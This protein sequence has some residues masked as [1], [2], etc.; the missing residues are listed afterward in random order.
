M[1]EVIKKEPFCALFVQVDE[2]QEVDANLWD[3][4]NCKAFLN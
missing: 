2:K 4:C 1:L 3:L